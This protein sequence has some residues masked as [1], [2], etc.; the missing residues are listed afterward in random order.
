MYRHSVQIWP[1]I[2]VK[3]GAS[4]PSSVALQQINY[5]ADC[6]GSCLGLTG[7]SRK[8]DWA[9]LPTW[10]YAIYTVH[11]LKEGGLNSCELLTL[12]FLSAWDHLLSGHT[13]TPNF[14]LKRGCFMVVSSFSLFI[15]SYTIT[16]TTIWFSL[17]HRSNW[18]ECHWL[19]NIVT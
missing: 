7:W 11:H 14:I 12:H 10:L 6:F 2:P 18:H 1:Q 13:V 15:Y 3:K 16:M 17:I 5:T 8:K 9:A 19:N 4:V